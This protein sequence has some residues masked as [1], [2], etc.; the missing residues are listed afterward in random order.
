MI[1]KGVKNMNIRE[2]EQQVLSKYRSDDEF[3]NF[4]KENKN[5]TLVKD[6]VDIR[7]EEKVEENNYVVEAIAGEYLEEI[8]HIQQ[9][10]KEEIE[11]YLETL[12]EDE[13]IQALTEGNLRE[14]A[15]IAFDYLIAGIDYLDLIQEGNIGII[16]ALENY[17]PS[18][19]ELLEYL[20][21]WARKEMIL[22]IDERVETEKYMYKGY[23]LKRKEEL[24][25]HEI[26]SALEEDDAEAVMEEEMSQEEKSEIIGE[27][28][29]I[30]ET[31]DFRSIPKKMSLEEEDMLKR[32]Y[33][34]VG[35]KRES[36]FEIENALEI[37]RG[38]GE[39]MFEK[40]L[41]KLSLG[42]GRSLKI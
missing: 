1:G 11:D 20:K 38:T 5:L 22:F 21:L 35:E 34:L 4:L 27:K 7:K 13:S 26:V 33:G 12:D 36:L 19:G 31:L 25:E 16:K 32:Y 8:S 9:L 6:I 39:Q 24:L 30:L 17:R 29:E 10:S 18:N 2:F 40:A 23:F 15:N 14:V 37:P 3:I 42:G 41:T 28:I